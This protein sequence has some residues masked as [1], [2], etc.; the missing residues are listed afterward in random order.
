VLDHRNLDVRPRVGHRH[1]ERRIEERTI[2][3][4]ILGAELPP[5]GLEVCR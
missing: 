1:R 5:V 4:T 3:R 2:V